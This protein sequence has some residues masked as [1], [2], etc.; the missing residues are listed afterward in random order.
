MGFFSSLFSLKKAKPAAPERTPGAKVVSHS[1]TGTNYRQKE[2][3]AMGK[4]NQ[5]YDL[6]KRELLKRWPNGVTVY[7]YTFSPQKAE[8]VPE[9]ENPHDP[10]AI[11]VLV[12]GM[13]VGYIKAG[14][15]AHIH[16][17]IRENR[18][19][20]IVPKISGGKY[21]EV[22]SYDADAKRSEDFEFDKGSSPFS[23]R[24]DISE[25]PAAEEGNQ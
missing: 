10:K 19:A 4:K 11:K 9:P 6:N 13:H 3:Q 15:C 24:L 17:L 5:A 14:S 16:R 18:I 22:Y 23:V 7:E 8:L 12:D 2:I 1:V 25:L 20:K 21:K